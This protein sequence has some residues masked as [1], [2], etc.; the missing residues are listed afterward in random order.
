MQQLV[1]LYFSVG[2]VI[3]QFIMA[4]K[5]S[6]RHHHYP[7]LYRSMRILEGMSVFLLALSAIVMGIYLLGN[8]QSFLPDSQLMLL[9]ILRVT[10]ALCGFATVYY[11]VALIVWMVT[12][13]HILLGRLVYA[14]I[15]GVFALLLSL[16]AHLVSVIIQPVT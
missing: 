10:S 6:D 3:A 1:L 8:Y 7:T 12:R 16:S 13:R 2:S 11:G 4:L 5:H 14:V 9:A 15:A